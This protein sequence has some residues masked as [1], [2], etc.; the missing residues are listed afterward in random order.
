MLYLS[1][2]RLVVKG[3]GLP[4]EGEWKSDAVSILP[5]ALCLT[6]PKL[7]LD[8]GQRKGDPSARGSGLKLT[9]D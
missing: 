2:C 1:L 3:G 8:G 9:C 5:V 6:Y 4:G 7:S